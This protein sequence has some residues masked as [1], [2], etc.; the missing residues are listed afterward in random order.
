M[1]PF[2]PVWLRKFTT[3]HPSDSFLFTCQFTP[4]KVSQCPLK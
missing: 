1:L 2:A 3:V 4:P